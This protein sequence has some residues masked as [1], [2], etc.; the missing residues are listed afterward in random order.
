MKQICIRP[1]NYIALVRPIASTSKQLL[2][3]FVIQ[4]KLFFLLDYNG[5][6]NN[7]F[8]TNCDYL[9]KCCIIYKYC[10]YPNQT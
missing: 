4:L 6:E 7:T 10:G 1:K 9:T 5:P 8:Y 3:E 2:T